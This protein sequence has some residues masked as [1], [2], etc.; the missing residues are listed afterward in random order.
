MRCGAFEAEDKELCACYMSSDDAFGKFCTKCEREFKIFDLATFFRVSN[1]QKG[2]SPVIS[3]FSG[4]RRHV[5]SV[6]F[7][8]VA[9]LFLAHFRRDANFNV[10]SSVVFVSYYVQEIKFIRKETW[11]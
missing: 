1:C 2:Q 11:I 4:S 9:S 10:T 3:I 5:Y 8:S 7:L 6:V